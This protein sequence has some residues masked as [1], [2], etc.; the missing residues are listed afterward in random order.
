MNRRTDPEISGD[1]L[2]EMA[3]AQLADSA[4]AVQVPPL[5][6]RAIGPRVTAPIAAA[7]SQGAK[8]APKA[9]PRSRRILG[10]HA[11]GDVV[12]AGLGVALG[13]TCALF[14]WYIFFNQDQFGPRAFTFEGSGNMRVPTEVAYRPNPIGEPMTPNEAPRLELD[15]LPTGTLPPG[16]G[17]TEPVPVT[18]QPFPADLVRYKL[19]HVANG[20]AMIEDADGIWVVQRGS[21]LPDASQVTSIERRNGGW[22]LVTSADRVLELRN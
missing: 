9:R 7:P 2:V 12:V 14:P 19:V 8:S 22:V 17:S 16:G 10:R 6:K 1:A 20:R 4:P 18:Q 21:R 5:P 11:P 15:F 3:L 13:L